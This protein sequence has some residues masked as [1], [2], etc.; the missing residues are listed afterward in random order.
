MSASDHRTAR[1]A[2]LQAMALRARK[3]AQARHLAETLCEVTR[4]DALQAR[5]REMA[6]ET[7]AYLDGPI[8]RGALA[9][10]LAMGQ[11]LASQSRACADQA[12]LAADT[13]ARARQATAQL[14]RREQMMQER[15][16]EAQARVAEA[17]Q[18]AQDRALADLPRR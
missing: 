15:A 17:R 12:R 3:V 4:L 18:D 14:N 5:M 16:T 7:Q 11:V 9:S 13:A 6:D 2:R 10:S 8:T 1:L